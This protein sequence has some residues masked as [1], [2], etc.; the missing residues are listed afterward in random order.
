MEENE[1]ALLSSS[2]GKKKKKEKKEKQSKMESKSL[3]P[4]TSDSFST[5]SKE[6]SSKKK[7]VICYYCKKLGHFK[8]TCYKRI[9][10]EKKKASGNVE[11][12]DKKGKSQGDAYACITIEEALQVLF[13]NPWIFDSGATKH[14]TG[15]RDVFS[16][17]S[18]STGRR[19]TIAYGND[20]DVVGIGTVTLKSR[21]GGNFQISDVLYAPEMKK[22]LLSVSA[23]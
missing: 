12:D 18:Y 22:N 20:L 4:S 7:E 8:S 9:A 2:K 6:K 10:A 16:S 11:E 21:E 19:V 1:E 13:A 15:C 17:L 14:M 5:T 3:S 23:F